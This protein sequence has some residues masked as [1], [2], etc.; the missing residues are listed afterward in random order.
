MMIEG[1]LVKRKMELERKKLGK[2]LPCLSITLG[3]SRH[4]L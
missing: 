3:K 2:V 1:L 4:G